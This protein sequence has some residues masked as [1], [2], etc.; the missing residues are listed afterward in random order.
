MRNAEG[1]FSPHTCCFHCAAAGK[2]IFARGA[3][4]YASVEA[5]FAQSALKTH[6]FLRSGRTEHSIFSAQGC[7]R[8]IARGERGNNVD[9]SSFVREYVE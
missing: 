8:R 9:S 5:L 6:V 4:D 3:H 7:V 2:R 1:M